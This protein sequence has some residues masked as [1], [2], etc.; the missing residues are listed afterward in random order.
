LLQYVK[1]IVNVATCVRL[2]DWD[3]GLPPA[4]R[5]LGNLGSRVQPEAERPMDNLH[6]IDRHLEGHE[7][8]SKELE[9]AEYGHFTAKPEG[10]ASEMA[11]SGSGQLSIRS[12]RPPR[13][14]NSS[15]VSSCARRCALTRGNWL[16]TF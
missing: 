1:N 15:T 6:R 4:S 10:A 2:V 3:A 16:W 12:T 9:T 11:S 14:R 5:S 13:A 7:A 8:G